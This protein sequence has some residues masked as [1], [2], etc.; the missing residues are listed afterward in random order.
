VPKFPPKKAVSWSERRAPSFQIMGMLVCYLHACHQSISPNAGFLTPVRMPPSRHDLISSSVHPSIFWYR[1]T[2][3]RWVDELRWRHMACKV[4]IT[5]N[6]H[7][8]MSRMSQ[9]CSRLVSHL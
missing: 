2:S 9:C 3:T 6:H 7:R 8:S 1:R 4:N 5:I